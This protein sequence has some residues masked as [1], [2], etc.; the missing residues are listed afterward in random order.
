MLTLT[1]AQ[2]AAGARRTSKTRSKAVLAP[3]SYPELA[4]KL[5][6]QRARQATLPVHPLCVV[7]CWMTGRAWQADTFRHEFRRMAVLAGIRDTLQFRD[8]RATAM[9]ELADAGADIIDMSTHSQHRT[10]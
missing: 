5:D 4:A 6:T 1:K 9:T 8:L 3:Q 10:A 7:I 2:L